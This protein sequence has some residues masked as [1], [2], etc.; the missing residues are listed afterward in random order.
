MATQ[1]RGHDDD[2]VPEIDGPTLPVG[3]PSIIQ[4]LEQYVEDIGVRLFDLVKEEDG[5]WTASDCLGQ[6]PPFFVA[7]VAGRSADQAGDRML[8]HVL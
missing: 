3:Q 7:Y 1:V 4:D 5:I 2:R 8:L 6:L